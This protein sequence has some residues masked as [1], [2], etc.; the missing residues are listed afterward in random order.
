MFIRCEALRRTGL[1]PTDF[2]IYLDDL[3]LCLRIWDAGYEIWSC[4]AAVIRHKFSATMGEGARARRKY[5]LNTRNR[6]RLIL[7]NFPGRRLPKTMA[8]YAIAEARAVGRALRD[9]EPWRVAA[10][11]RSWCSGLGYLRS[12][13]AARA[14]RKRNGLTWGAFWPLV[15]TDLMFFEGTEFPQSGWY[16]SRRINGREYRPMSAKAWCEAPA[17][18]LTIRHANPYPRLGATHVEVR[19]AGAPLAELKTGDMGEVTLQAPGGRVEFVSHRVFEAEE[20][21]ERVDLG[22]WIALDSA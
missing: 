18:S 1:F 21:G 15:R 11:A 16:V 4:P 8:W 17:G 7:R 12:T 22:G 10:H 6:I 13:V 14:A 2:E 19:V 5:Y 20:T 9:G 3:D